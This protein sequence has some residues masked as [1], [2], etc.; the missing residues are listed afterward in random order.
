MA[1]LDELNAEVDRKCAQ[2]ELHPI[3]ALL[4]PTHQIGSLLTPT[5]TVPKPKPKA[6]R[7]AYLPSTQPCLSHGRQPT[8][9]PRKKRKQAQQT[10]PEISIEDF[11]RLHPPVRK[12]GGIA[13]LARKVKNGVIVKAL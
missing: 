7:R 4:T 1:T 6:R 2:L 11:I 9:A 3:G 10:P 13:V 8:T 12:D 5:V